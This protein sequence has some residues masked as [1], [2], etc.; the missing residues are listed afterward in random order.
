MCKVFAISLTNFT[1]KHISK[2]LAMQRAQSS[3]Y[4]KPSDILTMRSAQS[5]VNPKQ[6]KN[7]SDFP[8]SE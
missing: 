4:C 1:G 2:L 8:F 6:K 5:K 3:T 7:N